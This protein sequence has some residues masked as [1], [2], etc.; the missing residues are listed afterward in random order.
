L[1]KELTTEHQQFIDALLAHKG[2]VSKAAAEC[3]YSAQ[4]GYVLMKTLRDDIIAAAEHVLALHTPKAVFAL[5][6]GVD[7]ELGMGANNV[8]ESAKQ[9]LDRAGIVKKDKVEVSG[10]AG[11]IFILPVKEIS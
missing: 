2:V 3:G 10:P 11:G 4:Y 7:G 6:D 9:I 5:I 8:I 1:R